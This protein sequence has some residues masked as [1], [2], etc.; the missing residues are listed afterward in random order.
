M[1]ERSMAVNSSEQVPG[2]QTTESTVDDDSK[3][4]RGESSEKSHDSGL[5]HDASAD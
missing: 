1:T 4:L 2:Q 3:S 5:G